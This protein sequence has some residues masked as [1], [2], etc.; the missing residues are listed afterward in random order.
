MNSLGIQS[1][2]DRQTIFSVA[3]IKTFQFLSTSVPCKQNSQFHLNFLRNMCF[4]LINSPFNLFNCPKTQTK[5]PHIFSKWIFFF[6]FQINSFSLFCFC[7]VFP[8]HTHTRLIR[9]KNIFV[10]HSNE[11]CQSFPLT[12]TPTHTQIYS[13]YYL[14]RCHNI[15][16]NQIFCFT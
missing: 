4:L 11:F 1:L 7:L 6:F 14:D 8:R 5:I 3:T 12:H 13:F 10:W 2:T 9:N 15:F 16:S